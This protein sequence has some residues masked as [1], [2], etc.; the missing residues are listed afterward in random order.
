M[1]FTPMAALQYIYLHQNNFSET[2]AAALNLAADEINTHSLRGMLGLQLSRLIQTSR[3]CT[4]HRLRATWMH[5]F[6]DTDAALLA[7]FGTAGA[8]AMSIRG[9]NLGRDW[10]VLGYGVESKRNRFLS[11]F[12]GYDIQLNDRQTFHVGSGGAQLRW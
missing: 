6:L 11:L 12:A 9:L 8:P 4:T 5:E 1:R 7:R 10:A 2:G 3:A